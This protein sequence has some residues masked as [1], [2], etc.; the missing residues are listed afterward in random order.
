MT[1]I[2]ENLFSE[3]RITPPAN[4]YNTFKELF[5]N[6]INEDWTEENDFW[7]VIFYD[8]QKENI[9]Q[10]N[11]D[12]SLRETRLNMNKD[13]LPDFITHSIQAK[14][15][16]MNIIAIQKPQMLFWEI[17]YRDKDLN[18]YLSVLDADGIRISHKKL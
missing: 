9:A 14:G 16:I 2:L 13:D 4:I 11:F 5:P 8:N 3:D 1:E 7:E 12:G 6:S 15:E 10:L 18:R 17:I